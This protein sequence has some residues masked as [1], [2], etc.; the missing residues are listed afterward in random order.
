MTDAT[1][2]TVIDAVFAMNAYQHNP[3]D[4]SWSNNLAAFF[5]N[6]YAGQLGDY[7]L[8]AVSLA[9]ENTNNNFL[10]IA[11]RSSAG[12][13]IISYRGTS[14]LLGSDFFNGDIYNGYGVGAGSPYGNDARDAVTFYQEVADLLDDPWQGA[15]DITVVGHSLG[16]GLAGFV[17]A[18]YGLKGVLFDN[19]TFNNAA[20]SAY[21]DSLPSRNIG[22]PADQI[23]LPAD[24]A[25]SKEFYGTQTPYPNNLS[26]LSAY[27]VTGELLSVILPARFFQTPPVQYLDSNGGPRGILALH[28]MSLLTLLLYADVEQDTA[29]QS[30]GVS[31]INALYNNSLGAAVGGTDA[32]GTSFT[33]GQMSTIIAYSA[34]NSG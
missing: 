25:F 9:D 8:E 11:Y 23:D 17:G 15:T 30:I 20:S 4:G 32:S 13:T 12:Q 24:A 19:M 21:S 22:D 34:L 29:W 27:A 2:A 3:D 14:S 10:A 28:S 6:L 1:Y 7:S 5:P 26:D 16:G 31:F 18:I 33:A